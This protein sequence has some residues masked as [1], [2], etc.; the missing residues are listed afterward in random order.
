[1]SRKQAYVELEADYF[2]KR[3]PEGRKRLFKRIEQLGFTVSLLQSILCVHCKVF[4]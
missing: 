2:D 1:M 3:R 4:S